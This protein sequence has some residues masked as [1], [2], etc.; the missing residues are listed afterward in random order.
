[1]SSSRIALVCLLCAAVALA[2][3]FWFGAGAGAYVGRLADEPARG[4]FAVTALTGIR[5]GHTERAGTMYELDV[6]RGLLS[7]NEFAESPAP[8]LVAELLAINPQSKALAPL[9]REWAT[10]MADYRKANPSPFQ[11]AL[12]HFPGETPEQSLMI[13]EVLERNRSNMKAIERMVERYASK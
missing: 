7:L 6:D 2:L 8:R 11:G 4:G 1:M 13:D 12:D 3:G 9:T 5:A 10:K